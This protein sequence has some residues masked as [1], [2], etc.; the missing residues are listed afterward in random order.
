MHKDELKQ[1][2]LAAYDG[3]ADQVLVVDDETYLSQALLQAAVADA[4]F[5][6]GVSDEASYAKVVKWAAQVAAHH[7]FV[8]SVTLTPPRV[9]FGQAGLYWQR[10]QQ[11]P[12]E[13]P[14]LPQLTESLVASVIAQMTPRRSRT[15]PE[16]TLVRADVIAAVADLV[17]GSGH[18]AEKRA[19]LAEAVDRHMARWAGHVTGA[20]T[21]GMCT[22]SRCP[23][24]AYAAEK[25]L[26]A[27]L[28]AGNTVFTLH[29]LL[30]EAAKAAYGIGNP[31]RTYGREDV[32]WVQALKEIVLRAVAATGYQAE[33]DDLFAPQLL[34]LPDDLN[35]HIEQV[36]NTAAPYDYTWRSSNKRVLIAADIEQAIRQRIEDP[37]S[38][39]H[40]QQQLQPLL[41][42]AL[43]TRGFKTQTR[44]INSDNLTP[45]PPQTESRWISVYERAVSESVPTEHTICLGDPKTMP[46]VWAPI[47]VIDDSTRELVCL[48]L[49]GPLQ[50]VKANW[51]KVIGGSSSSYRLFNVTLRG[52]KAVDFTIIKATLPI[53]WADWIILHKQAGSATAQPE[54]PVYVLDGDNSDDDTAI[55]PAR[56]FP[57]LN[58]TV[59]TPLQPHW[60]TY[61][62]RTGIA[63]NLIQ[64]AADH[65]VGLHA[66]RVDVAADEAWDE[67]I[68]DGLRH[69]HIVMRDADGNPVAA[70]AASDIISRY[71][72]D[73]ALEDG[74]LTPTWQPDNPLND[75]GHEPFPTGHGRDDAR[76]GRDGRDHR[77]AHLPETAC[78][79]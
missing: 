13:E 28:T 41:T 45:R 54:Q 14:P 16:Q 34:A 38:D 39:Y 15:M 3:V 64:P 66:W 43:A 17:L 53:G 9:P 57:L 36:L 74:A 11:P 8:A 24:T 37:V 44:Q 48:R 18:S 26:V 2:V 73:D 46:S 42:Q 55:V 6:E 5:P 4:V 52:R 29:Q 32:P 63:A 19:D 21:N 25:A 27:L 31:Y 1:R 51:T 68:S 78:R 7:D 10:A 59:G 33:T 58:R 47:A 72:V 40:W 61:L 23:V 30:A 79:L 70:N 20:S 76:R 62:W 65:A 50:A 60:A 35:A 69:G 71:T 75:I 12:T 22:V 77:P 67:I 49:V 56:F